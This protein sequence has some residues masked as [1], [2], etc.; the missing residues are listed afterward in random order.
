MR[1]K[2]NKR[3]GEQGGVAL[4]WPRPLFQ[5]KL[6]G[7]TL[8]CRDTHAHTGRGGEAETLHFVF[9]FWTDPTIDVFSNV[10]A[11]LT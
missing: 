2:E 3:E 11:T 5:G 4:S 8:F 1:V 10:N 9:R 6:G 7:H